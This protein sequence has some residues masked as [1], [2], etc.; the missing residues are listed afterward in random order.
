M[1]ILFIALILLAVSGMFYSLFGY[2]KFHP[3]FFVFFSSSPFQHN[4]KWI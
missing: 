3:S 4:V 2:E 1:S